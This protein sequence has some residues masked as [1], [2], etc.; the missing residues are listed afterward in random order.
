MAYTHPRAPEVTGVHPNSPARMAYQSS[1]VPG[2]SSHLVVL[3]GRA[4]LPT[5]SFVGSPVQPAHTQPFKSEPRGSSA[6]HA[7]YTHFFRA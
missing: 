1:F 2:P 3:E 4:V 5:Q 7:P 6:H